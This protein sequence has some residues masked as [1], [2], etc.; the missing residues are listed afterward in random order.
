MYFDMDA[1]AARVI[2]RRAAL[3]LM[4][5]DGVACANEA[6]KRFHDLRHDLRQ[7]ED[8]GDLPADL[9]RKLI[10]AKR[11]ARGSWRND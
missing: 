9:E 6:Q 3:N 11:V 2:A 1:V 8:W 7:R 4:S 10:E 5:K